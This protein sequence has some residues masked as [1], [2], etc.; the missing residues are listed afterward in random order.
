MP[1]RDVMLL[2]A[3]GSLGTLCRF[4]LLAGVNRWSPSAFPWGTLIVN[5]LGCFLFGLVWQISAKWEFA[6]SV[7]MTL[8]TGFLGAF[9]TYS[10]FAFETYR[11]FE[12]GE[13]K[14]AIFNIV[15]HTL[16]GLLAV[17]LGIRTGVR[18]GS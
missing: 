9:T 12:Q 11:L 5:T 1:L 6:S 15:A 17:G 2:A 10:T 7:R 14:S 16:L 3:F 8:L 18:T 13:T 4:G